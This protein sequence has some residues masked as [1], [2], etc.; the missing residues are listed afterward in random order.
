[1]WTLNVVPDS[2]YGSGCGFTFAAYTVL[3]TAARFEDWRLTVEAVEVP[4]L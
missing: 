1:M 2:V 3:Q 4:G